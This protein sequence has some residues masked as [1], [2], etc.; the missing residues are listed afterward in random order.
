MVGGHWAGARGEWP[1]HPREARAKQAGDER[2]RLSR[3]ERGPGT[4]A[5]GRSVSMMSRAELAKRSSWKPACVPLRLR[6][7]T[8]AGPGGGP[9]WG[10]EPISSPTLSSPSQ[11]GASFLLSGRHEVLKPQ[12]DCGEGGGTRDELVRAQSR[13]DGSAP[14]PSG[15][16]CVRLAV[17][18]DPGRAG[19]DEPRPDSLPGPVPGQGWWGRAG[20]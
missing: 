19:G 8:S 20:G 3:A 15:K 2:N 1:H 18:A 14:C 9:G 12:A 4:V 11:S 16:I 13:A 10:L 17:W 7:E 5:R 6:N